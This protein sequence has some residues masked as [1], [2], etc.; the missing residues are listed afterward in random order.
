MERPLQVVFKQMEASEALESLIRERASR[1]EKFHAHIVGARVV[2]E[3]PHHAPESG[4]VP[5]KITVEVDVAGRP[6]IVVKSEEQPHDSKGG[7]TGV[8]N[9]VFDSVQRRLEDVASTQGGAMKRSKSA[10]VP[11]G[12][13]DEL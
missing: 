10:S 11:V 9:R 6:R 8:V 12:A 13:P 2:V 5:L 7:K 3:V 1:L 4:K